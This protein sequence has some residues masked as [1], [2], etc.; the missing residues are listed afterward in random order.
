[1]IVMQPLHFRSSSFRLKLSL[2]ENEI[3]EY[4]KGVSEHF[5]KVQI[6]LRSV[7]LSMLLV[8]RY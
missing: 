3:L 4:R 5:D 2:D 7:V 1:M 8:L 6:V